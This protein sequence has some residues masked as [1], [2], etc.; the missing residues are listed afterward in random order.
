ML[1]AVIFDMDG[2]LGDTL[3]L[4]IEA[5]RQC[6]YETAERIPSEEE[7]TRYFGLSD[8]G[9]LGGLLGMDPDAPALPIGAFVRIYEK[10][11]PAIAPKPFKGAAEL[12]RRLKERGLLIGLITG[13]E[14]YTAKPTL[15]QFRMESLF[16]LELMGEPTHNCKA[17]RLKEAMDAWRLQPDELVYVGDA[18]S[19]I[20]LCHSV[21]VRIINAAWGSNAAKDEAA[22]LALRPEYRLDSF[23]DLEPLII[24][25]A[26]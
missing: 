25:L 4:C 15:R 23:D 8:R 17:E 21:G 26:S 1:K 7:V 11:H 22:C 12:L 14:A 3:T 9:V 10:L 6:V 24:S 18:P 13:K 16:D 2:T 5:Y 20:A 19:D